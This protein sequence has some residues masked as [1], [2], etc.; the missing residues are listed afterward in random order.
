MASITTGNGNLDDP[1]SALLDHHRNGCC[2]GADSI[3][4]GSV[5]HVLTLVDTSVLIEKCRNNLEA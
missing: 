4:I 1:C 2:L 3:W 5:F